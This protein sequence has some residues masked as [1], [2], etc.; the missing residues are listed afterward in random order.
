MAE[1]IPRRE[2]VELAYFAAEH[3]ARGSR[4][5]EL[6]T[7][8][9]DVGRYSSCG[10][11]AQCVLYVG[12]HRGPAINRAEFRG[13]KTGANI[14][15]L[16]KLWERNAAGRFVTDIGR[17]LPGDLL[18]LD[19]NGPSAHVCVAIT[20]RDDR[21]ELLTADYGQPGGKLHRC[22]ITRMK[23]GGVQIRGRRWTHHISLASVVWSAPA[24]TVGEWAIARQAPE[25]ERLWLGSGK[26][27][28]ELLSDCDLG[29]VN[30]GQ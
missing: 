9:R 6:V 17:L 21:T 24:L 5:N 3:G 2:V 15:A 25:I 14:S 28:D 27:A 8:G 13:W 4:V 12:G 16:W 22:P 10:D 7:E 11:L 19:G 1:Y 23:S 30:D 18:L 29:R 26:T 20:M